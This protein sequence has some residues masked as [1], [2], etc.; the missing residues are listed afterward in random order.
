MIEL[1]PFLFLA[2]AIL[3]HWNKSKYYTP[4]FSFL[5]LISAFYF[6]YINIYAIAALACYYGICFFYSKSTKPFIKISLLLAIILTSF[7]FFLHLVPGFNNPVVLNQHQFSSSSVPFTLYLNFDKTFIGLILLTF[8]VSK[9]S[10]V[11]VLQ[12]KTIV[13][14]TLITIAVLLGPGIF[15]RHINWDP[16]VGSEMIIWSLNNLLFVCVAEEMLFRG[17]IQN[18]LETTFKDINYGKI[19]ALSI[20]AILFGI[21]HFKGGLVYVILSTMAGV[22]YGYAYF[23]TRRV[24]NSILV[25]FLLNQCHLFLFTYPKLLS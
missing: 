1:T 7:L 17:V 8:F 20:A 22:F 18:K 2:L 9:E 6:Q 12:P 25:H 14:I 3:F 24:E 4:V 21:A 13:I 23:K 19:I 11:K 16:K 15:L 5:S 10:L